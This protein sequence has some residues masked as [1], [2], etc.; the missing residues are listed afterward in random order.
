MKTGSVVT[1]KLVEFSYKVFFG[2]SKLKVKSIDELVKKT[3]NEL[4]AI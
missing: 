3:G 1:D 4:T 2:E